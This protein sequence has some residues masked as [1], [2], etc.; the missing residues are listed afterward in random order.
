MDKEIIVFD[1]DK[2]LTYNDT[3]FGFF[4]H[5]SKLNFLFPFKVFLYFTLMICAKF[6]FITNQRLKEYGVLIFLKTKSAKYINSVSNSYVKKIKFNRL[7]KQYD[8]RNNQIFYVVSA[9]FEDYIKT[10]FPRNVNVIGS[11]MAYLMGEVIGLQFNCYKENK[12]E[13][14][15]SHGIYEIDVFYT[16][17]YSDLALASIS[18]KI[19]IVKGDKLYECKNVDEFNIYF[20]NKK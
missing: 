4:I 2:T 11:K 20:S 17:S 15:E 10:I 1:F 3:L 9:S 16:D 8:F 18:K 13:A 19:I 5:A 6:N 12:I 7:F 14:L